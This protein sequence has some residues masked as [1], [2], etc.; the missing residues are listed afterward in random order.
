ML[1]VH[2]LSVHYGGIHAVQDI[3]FEVPDGQIVTLIGA[4]GA[5]KSTILRAIAGLRAPHA[6][7]TS[8]TTG[9][10]WSDCPRK[11]IVRRG[12]TQVPEGRRVFRGICRWRK[13]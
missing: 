13:I 9:M 12:L 11:E 2:D 1:K 8:S 4:N 6:A 7:A 3:S 10:S 5:G